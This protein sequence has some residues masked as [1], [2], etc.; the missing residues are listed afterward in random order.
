LIEKKGRSALQSSPAEKEKKKENRRG[1]EGGK[2]PRQVPLS[3]HR[4]REKTLTIFV[5][6]EEKKKKRMT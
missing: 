2:T 5:S 6:S 3:V 4:K 1:K